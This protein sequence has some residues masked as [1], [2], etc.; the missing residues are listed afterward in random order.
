MLLSN[1]MCEGGRGQRRL[2]ALGI[3]RK[4]RSA[5]CILGRCHDVLGDAGQPNLM[6]GSPIWP[7]ARQSSQGRCMAATQGGQDSSQDMEQ[8]YLW[9]K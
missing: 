1:S 9:R 7:R 6:H 8:C 4:F 3:A 2:A 5:E